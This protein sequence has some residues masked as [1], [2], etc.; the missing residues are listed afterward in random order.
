MNERQ[1]LICLNLLS[2]VGPIKVTRLIESFGSALEIFNQ[3]LRSLCAVDGIG[4]KLAS[5]ILSAPQKCDYLQEE[6]LAKNSGVE[7]I[8]RFCPEYPDLLKYIPDPPIV[9]YVRGNSKILNEGHRAI[10]MVGSRRPTEYG[11][12]MAELLSVSAASAGWMTVSGLAVGVDSAAHRSTLDAGGETVAVLGSGLGRLYPQENLSLARDITVKGAVISEFPMTYPPDKRSFP[13]RNRIISGLTSGTVV[14]EAGLNSGTLITANQAADQGRQVFAV[15]GRADRP[16]S[17]GC[18]S[19]IRDGAKLIENFSD[20]LDEFNNMSLFDFSQK[21]QESVTQQDDKKDERLVR[22]ALTLNETEQ[23]IVEFLS[24][25]ES[26]VDELV[27]YL[28]LP[29]GK[30]FATLIEME[31]KRL[32]RPLPGRRYALRN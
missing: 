8:T 26:T 24:Q 14:I 9:L 18:H 15:P 29:V 30:I 31:T 17:R 23:R 13:M 4:P 21:E 28:E 3:N 32:V 10:A 16:Q 6:S 5:G 19:L 12:H 27:V 20:V 22:P 25:G 2:G 11:I 1:A 7:I